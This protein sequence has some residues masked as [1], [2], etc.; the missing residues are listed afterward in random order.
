MANFQIET[1]LVMRLSILIEN[2]FRKTNNHLKI[3]KIKELKI[4]YIFLKLIFLFALC[5][6]ICADDEKKIIVFTYLIEKNN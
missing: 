4:F 6:C 1:R 5:D 3:L 2:Y